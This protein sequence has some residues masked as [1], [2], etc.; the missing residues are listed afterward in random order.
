[1]ETETTNECHWYDLE[2]GEW[3]PRASLPRG[4]NHAGHASDGYEYVYAF[5]GRS[6]GNAVGVGFDLVQRHSVAN[7]TW[8]SSDDGDLEPLLQRRGGMGSS[9]YYP[10]LNSYIV[11]GGETSDYDAV[12]V[13]DGLAF[14]RVDVYNPERNAWRTMAPLPI[15]MHGVS[16]I[17]IGD[18]I[19]I[20]GGG[21]V[22]GASKSRYVFRF[23]VEH[24][25]IFSLDNCSCGVEPSLEDGLDVPK[26]CDKDLLD[27]NCGHQFQEEYDF[28]DGCEV[29]YCSWKPPPRPPPPPSPSTQPS[30]SPSR[31][32][33]PLDLLALLPAAPRRLRFAPGWLSGGG[34][35]P[36]P[37]AL[38]T[39]ARMERGRVT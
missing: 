27:C 3:E 23:A 29:C 34:E 8:V 4:V 22:A 30:P 25:D 6:G 24:A 5:G 26:T 37:C 10:R 18:E 31:P 33:P 38:R 13:N 21:I 16:P 36:P 2:T 14:Y 17:L 7:D 9:V 32:L 11:F 39:W 19:Y 20:T 28:E 1:V 15:G 12:G 35:A